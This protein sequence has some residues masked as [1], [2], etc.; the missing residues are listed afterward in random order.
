MI[1]QQELQTRLE[2]AAADFH[3]P[4]A[5]IALIR[6]DLTVTAV[7]GVANV[8][9]RSAVVP[10]TLFAAGSVTKVFT[11]SLIMSYVDAGLVDLASP[12]Q[13]YL[14]DFTLEDR[15]RSRLVTVRMLLDHTSGLPGNWMLD[16]PKS[17]HMIADIVA[18][19]AHMPFNSEP[20]QRWSYSNAGMA[21]LGRLA[22]VLSGTTFDDALAARILGPLGL[23]A[24]ADTDEMI[25]HSVAVGHLVDMATGEVQ[26]VPRFQLDRSNSPAGAT[27]FCDIGAMV[28]FARMHLNGGLAPDGTRVLSS[29]S[30]TAMR[31]R[32]ADMPWGIGYDQMGLGWTIRTNG[33]PTVVSH[34]GGNAGAHSSLAL[35]PDQQGAVAVL[36]N[37]TTGAAV[38]GLLT[39]HLLEECFGV[40]PVVPV[41]APAT[42]V[43][44]DLGRYPGRFTADDGEVT[45]TIENGRLRLAPFFAP[46]LL[47]SFYLMGFPPPVPDF[48]TPVSTDG[49]FISDRGTPVSFIDDGGGP[50]KYVY[51][52]RIYRRASV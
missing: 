22:E 23:H 17:P 28:T 6:G 38:H 46:G 37:G 50:P 44:A 1:T 16:L 39:T 49:R 4:G 42:P 25:L 29:A 12:V 18:R 36:T 13:A 34:T 45:L 32:H 3:L 15:S 31:T 35:V 10:E 20:G 33:G 7:T 41:T 21:V 5:A 8:R 52:G 43:E 9:T 26:V 14:P 27:L 47:R 48:L 2:R 24:T 30:V 40:G 51:V 11:A 19:L